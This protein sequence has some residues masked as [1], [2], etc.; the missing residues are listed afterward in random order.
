MLEITRLIDS[1]EYLLQHAVVLFDLDD[2]LYPEKDYVRSGYREISRHYT[3]IENMTD[4]L[5]SAFENGE[6]AIDSVLHR[7]GLLS[8]E[9]ISYCL[10]IYRK[11]QPKITI[12]PDAAELICTLKAHGIRLGLITDGRPE[13]QHAKIK[14]LEIEQYFEKIIITDELGSV[15]FRK[16]DTKAFEEMQKYFNVP[17]SSMV[18]VGDNPKKDFIA[19]KQLGMNSVYFK[20]PDG[21]YF[22]AMR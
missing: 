7:E 14:A 3:E 1:K 10:N 16:P 19:P 2:T 4:K 15:G 12:Y 6:K 17:Y 18:Y 20:N 9:A 5:W 22:N 11:H 21:L 8:P 13:G